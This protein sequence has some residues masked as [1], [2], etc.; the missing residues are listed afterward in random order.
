M[1]GDTIAAISTAAGQAAIGIVKISGPKAIS[2]TDKTFSA[3]N[4]KTLSSTS[5]F[6]LIHGNIID[7]K[8]QPVDEVLVSVMRGPKSY[9]GEDVVEINCHGGSVALGA[10][11]TLTLKNGARLAKPG[12]FTKRAYLNGRID[13]VQAEAVAYIIQ[14]K[15][16]L[17]LKAAQSQLDGRL[18]EVVRSLRAELMD[19]AVQLQAAIDFSD[20][21]V[22]PDDYKRLLASL[23]NTKKRIKKLLETNAAGC[24]L[25]DGIKTAIIGG[26]NVGKSSL[27]NAL[28]KKERAIVTEIAGTTRDLIEEIIDVKG[29]PLVLQDTAGIRRAFNEAESIGIKLS[30]NALEQADLVLLAIDASKK[31]GST[32]KL[33]LKQAS[34]EKT[35][36][37]LNKNDLRASISA[38]DINKHGRFKTTKVS[39][40]KL[41]GLDKLKNKIWDHCLKQQIEPADAVVATKRQAISL[42]NG[43]SYVERVETLL[44]N[45]ESEELV[46]FELSNAISNLSEVIGE[47]STEEVLDNLFS[48][49]CVGK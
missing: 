1:T 22:E 14:A 10:V 29:L 21:D 30:K 13:L 6:S 27:L 38:E 42:E 39:A 7:K 19:I 28:L 49:F 3:A 11:L 37:V 43:L 12:E 16:S 34:P 33:L 48:R 20:E 9:T 25:K 45:H 46:A 15:T 4:K 36:V 24:L 47:I 31:L 5:T 26:P 32:E 17:A 35:I 44:S 40:L 23:R 18:S 8:K 2:I 41:T